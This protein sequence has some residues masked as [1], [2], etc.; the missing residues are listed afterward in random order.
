[1][2]KNIKALTQCYCLMSKNVISE[3]QQAHDGPRREPGQR[4]IWWFNLSKKRKA[5]KLFFVHFFALWVAF[6][7]MWHHAAHGFNIYFPA[8][9]QWTWQSQTCYYIG[10]EVSPWH[11]NCTEIIKH[12][13]K[14]LISM[15]SSKGKSNSNEAHGG[16]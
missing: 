3:V 13:G 16:T 4:Q 9:A 7:F 12:R 5:C 15:I 11:F 2:I 10:R 14:N 8:Q 1:M 6:N